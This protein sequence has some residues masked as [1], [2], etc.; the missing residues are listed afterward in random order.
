MQLLYVSVFQAHYV[1]AQAII[2]SML[3]HVSGPASVNNLDSVP[4]VVCLDHESLWN[5]RC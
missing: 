5:G 2:T 1:K 3:V 4:K